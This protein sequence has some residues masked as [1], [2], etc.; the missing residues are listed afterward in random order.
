MYTHASPS[1]STETTSTCLK[2]LQACMYSSKYSAASLLHTCSIPYWPGLIGSYSLLALYAA[3]Q[4]QLVWLMNCSRAS[5][6]SLL[7]I[8]ACLKCP[9]G[10]LSREMCRF[11]VKGKSVSLSQLLPAV[12]S[13]FFFNTHLFFVNLSPFSRSF[14]CF[15]S[16]SSHLAL[17]PTR[18]LLSLDHFAC[19]I[20]FLVSL[21]LSHPF[22]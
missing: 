11:L 1:C 9:T 3:C 8:K 4:S 19:R 13:S 22:Q 20:F 12:H 6:D 16:P 14:F 7:A 5:A 10:R 15:S 2:R 17:V 18:S 21:L